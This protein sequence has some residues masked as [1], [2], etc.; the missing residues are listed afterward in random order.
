VNAAT[1]E[2]STTPAAGDSLLYTGHGSV[3][4]P[5]Y[6]VKVTAHFPEDQHVNF[7]Y[8]NATRKAK[9]L[10]VGHRP[11][12][13]N[14]DK[15]EVQKMLQPNGYTANIQGD[16]LDQF[17]QTKI[18]VINQV[19]NGAPDELSICKADVEKAFGR[20]K[21]PTLTMS[22]RRSRG[23]PGALR[24]L[25]AASLASGAEALRSTTWGGA[26]A[27]ATTCTTAAGQRMTMAIY[28]PLLATT[29]S[30]ATQAGSRVMQTLKVWRSTREQHR[31]R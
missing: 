27:S 3:D 13:N 29:N 26:R 31:I 6:L 10:L 19:K 4:R 20:R 11:V 21:L 8:Y 24:L 15:P 2:A 28:A 30:G 14:P 17:C 5:W 7:H 25:T 18:A 23:T 16:S 9:L 12:R 1:G 22:V